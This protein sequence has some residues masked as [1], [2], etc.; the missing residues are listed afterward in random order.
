MGV[1]KA[2]AGFDVDAST[3]TLWVFKKTAQKG[4]APKYSG[5]WIDTDASLDAT[6][7]SAILAERSRIT[8]VQEYQLLAQ[9]NE[10]SALRIDALETHAGLIL[11]QAAAEVA[12]R[13]VKE[14]QEI[15]NTDFYVIKL[16][17]GT[18]VLYAVR[19]TESSWQTKKMRDAI[20]VFFSNK[21]LGLDNKPSFRI[22]RHVDFF[23]FDDQVLIAHK[24]HFES[25]LSY[26][27]AHIEDFTALQKESAFKRI[28]SDLDPLVGF[29][30]ANKIYLRRACA[31]RAKGHYKNQDFMTRLRKF[32]GQHGLTLK[33][34]DD[35]RLM[36]TEETCADIIRALLDHRLSSPFS[37]QD[38]DV[39][40][41]IVV[42][43][44]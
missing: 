8:E 2:F 43:T 31:I 37:E 4:A 20:Y 11:E 13:K 14:M 5:R 42:S 15:R 16:A 34:T 29:V 17:K 28:F 1:P 23:I 39:D 24:G 36:P 22:S 10:N 18:K 6:L 26:K 21:K 27:E 3:L 40:N 12:A 9:N 44:T 7:K 41:A 19:K 32:H 33:F 30:G 25:I 35:G 38:Y